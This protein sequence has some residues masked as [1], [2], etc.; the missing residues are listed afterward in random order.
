MQRLGHLTP[1]AWAID[2]WIEVLSRG[3]G[4]TD[5]AR[6]LAVFTGFAVALLILA[7]VRLSRRVTCRP[8][9]ARPAARDERP[10]RSAQGRL[11]PPGEMDRRSHTS[12][13]STS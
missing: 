11:T 10:R 4:I 6:P 3:G 9:T 7:S 13:L 1:H 8:A 2:G 5:L 12:G